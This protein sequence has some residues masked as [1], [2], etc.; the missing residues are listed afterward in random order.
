MFYFIYGDIPLPL[1]YDEVIDKIKKENPDAPIQIFDASQ[2][3]ENNFLEAISINSMFSEKEIIVLK[4]TDKISYFEKFLKIVFSYDLSKKYII[5][6]Y[7]ESLNEYG[8]TQNEVPNK[9]LKLI[10][11]YGKTIMGRKSFE[12]R[13]LQFYI[14]KELKIS[15]YESEKL[16]EIIGDDLY[17]VKNEVEKIKNFIIGEPFSIEKILPILS[18]TNEYNLK[19][20]VE[21]FLKDKI[22]N[23]LLHTLD[24]NKEYLLF[25]Y[26]LS[27]ELTTLLK[28]KNLIEMGKFNSNI[29]YNNFKDKVYAEIKSYFK[30]NRG[31]MREYPIFL[32]INLATQYSK[33]FLIETLENLV[34][35]EYNIK[36]GKINEKT[37]T[38]NF[39]LKFFWHNY[40]TNLCYNY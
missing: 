18:I 4:R 21:L 24:E 14:E 9:I 13:A 11:T 1:K 5:L 31:Y 27:E 20:E 6:T 25:I 10:E 33:K 23:N 8:K 12:K 39:I 29:S 3:E 35:L 30:T 34:K 22:Y 32:K 7:E 40:A 16:S 37:G 38:E 17:K 15:E 36:I 26:I 28:I 19:K 2:K